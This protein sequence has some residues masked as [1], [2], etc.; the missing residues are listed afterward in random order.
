M[1]RHFR[2]FRKNKKGVIFTVIAIV[3]SVF[4]TTVFSGKVEQPIDYKTDLTE[5]R[6]RVLS[7]YVENFYDYAS[8][9]GSIA[10]YSALQGVIAE[11][12]ARNPK[13][14]NANFES[15]YLYCISTGNLTASTICPGMSNKTITSFLNSIVALA[16]NELNINSTY[17][18]N[19]MTVSQVTDAFSIEIKANITLRVIDSYANITDNRN[20]TSSVSVDGVPDPIYM[21][22][23]IY[24]QT[25]KKNALN[26]REGDWN[27][28]DMRDLYF[29]HTYR[30]YKEG[31]SI[32]N[33]IKGN[34]TPNIFGI[35]SLV[36]QSLLTM[37]VDYDVNDSMVD[38]LL[39]LNLK[40]FECKGNA[41]LV[42]INNSNVIPLAGPGGVYGFQID[43][44]HRLS[45]NV[46]SSDTD[47][48]CS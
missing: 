38:Y 30:N 4:F 27:I 37:G 29:N 24:N 22:D 21:I 16:R 25:I 23:G 42:K 6:I 35:E 8:G 41:T 17:T 14:Y 44:E 43:E 28:T 34:F 32:I 7:S 48:T 47:F 33:R 31:L 45:F 1:E 36:N 15:Q 5:T 20:I 9:A 46:S 13:S 18:I 19:N 10:G 40:T 26:K 12:G 3:L 11:M 2:A 39:W